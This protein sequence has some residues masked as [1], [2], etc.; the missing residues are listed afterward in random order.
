MAN[1]RIPPS[2]FSGDDTQTTASSTTH[3]PFV[4]FDPFTVLTFFETWLV[5]KVVCSRSVSS[6]CGGNTTVRMRSSYRHSREQLNSSC[7][8]CFPPRS[9]GL[10][11]WLLLIVH[12]VS[13]PLVA[14]ACP[15]VLTRWCVPGSAAAVLGGVQMRGS[16]SLCGRPSG[17]GKS[18]RQFC[19]HVT[20]NIL[21]KLLMT[22]SSASPCGSVL[23]VSLR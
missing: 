8:V 23:W 13:W 14:C 2:W 3:L 4:S 21:S 15:A 17:A 22:S 18:M 16:S 19:W 12:Y 5:S 7:R 11:V 6:S 9:V 1:F 20:G 10:G